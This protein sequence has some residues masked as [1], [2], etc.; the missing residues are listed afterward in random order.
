MWPPPPPPPPTAPPRPWQGGEPPPA[1]WQAE[2]PP[3]FW[4]P[5]PPPRQGPAEAWVARPY[6]QLLRGPRHRWWRPLAGLGVLIGLVAAGLLA[7]GVL[8]AA[9]L[10]ATDAGDAGPTDAEF[11]AWSI[12]PIGLLATNLFLAAFI[13]LAQVA[14]WVGHGW[15]PRWVA[16]VRPG[17]RWRWL[18][19]SAGV[20]LIVFAPLMAAFVLLSGETLNPEQ[21]VLLLLLVVL[22]TTP[23]QAAGEEYLFRGWM[24]QALGSVIKG[25]VAG[26][27]VGA[28]VS[29]SLFALA[30]GQQDVWLFA[31]R[32]AFGLIAS[33]LVWRTG[34]LEAA[35]AVHA[36]NN[37]IA[38]VATI[39]VGE[40]QDALT[41]TEA[42]PV[43]LG[44]D[45]AS[46]VV[47]ALII[48]R[49]ARR[50]RLPRLFVPPEPLAL[51]PAPVPRPGRFSG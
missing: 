40:L 32:F 27:V 41:S 28:L 24:A 34:G 48:D 35:I 25:A 4:Q 15:R 51:P 50:R 10:I 21:N 2:P 38:F 23:L 12:T 7:L 19:T 33:W 31:D 29:T 14:V 44:V 43:T 9:V 46:L 37:M 39:L 11:E 17:I 30:H 18:L 26:A 13:P 6:T 45:V 1:L 20:T 49:I 16:S 22:L 36:V 3:A 42:D 5:G 8:S 47:V